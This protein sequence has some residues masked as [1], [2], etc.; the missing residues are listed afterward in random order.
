[1]KKNH[2][3]FFA[4]FVVIYPMKMMKNLDN[5]ITRRRFLKEWFF[6]GCLAMA[7]PLLKKA[8]AAP[9]SQAVRPVKARHYRHLAG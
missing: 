4:S 2:F 6:W 7:F 3:F 5:K 8:T 9:I 1:M